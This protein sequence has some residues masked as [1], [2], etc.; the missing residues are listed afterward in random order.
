MHSLCVD[1]T[2]WHYY[3]SQSSCFSDTI[4]VMVYNCLRHMLCFRAFTRA[5]SSMIQLTSIVRSNS[6]SILFRRHCLIVVRLAFFIRCRFENERS[7]VQFRQKYMR[8]NISTFGKHD[9]MMVFSRISLYIRNS[10]AS[11]VVITSMASSV[12]SGWEAMLIACRPMSVSSRAENC[13][14]SPDKLASKSS[15]NHSTSAADCTDNSSDD[16]DRTLRKKPNLALITS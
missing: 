12:A 14:G 2:Q 15:G 10:A 7:P 8:S 5:K 1:V 3:T 6:L 9:C 13:P 4:S 11:P 16:I